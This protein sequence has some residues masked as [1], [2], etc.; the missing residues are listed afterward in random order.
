MSQQLTNA[1]INKLKSI[2]EYPLL[3]SYASEMGIKKKQIKSMDIDELRELLIRVT[4]E[5]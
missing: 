3:L 4:I 5:G 2:N 1:V